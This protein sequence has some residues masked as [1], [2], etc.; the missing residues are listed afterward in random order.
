MKHLLSILIF[1][2]IVSVAQSE[3]FVCQL[4]KTAATTGFNSLGGGQKKEFR[5]GLNIYEINGDTLFTKSLSD[6]L[7]IPL[8]GSDDGIECGSACYYNLIMDSSSGS[9][10]S[11]L[12]F[13]QID[14]ESNNPSDVWDIKH[15]WRFS[16]EAEDFYHYKHTRSSIY[17]STDPL[18]RGKLRDTGECKVIK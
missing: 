7:S 2:S 16:D 15:F 17:S 18:G 4:Y 12:V 6:E 9:I 10:E 13:L 14:A 5:N 1:F 11:Q 3:T 8:E